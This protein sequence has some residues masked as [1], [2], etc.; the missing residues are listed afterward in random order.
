MNTRL[1]LIVSIVVFVL[2]TVTLLIQKGA[3]YQTLRYLP[4]CCQSCPGGPGQPKT[5][6]STGCYKHPNGWYGCD[7]VGCDGKPCRLACNDPMN[8]G[9]NYMCDKKNCPSG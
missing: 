7:Y 4:P 5:P 6:K 1:I 8:P 9:N 3:G 2:L